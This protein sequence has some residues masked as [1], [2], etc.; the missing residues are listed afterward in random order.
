MR[1]EPMNT[2]IPISSYIMLQSHGC[3]YSCSVSDGCFKD[4]H[5]TNILH[6]YESIC[7]HPATASPTGLMALLAC[8]HAIVSSLVGPEYYVNIMSFVDKTQLEPGCSILL[9]NK[10]SSHTCCTFDSA[11]NWSE[12]YEA[13]IGC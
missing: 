11:S 10:V 4:I 13:L 12:V 8:S 5:Q 7:T 1:S 9:H 6:F 3:R 2:L